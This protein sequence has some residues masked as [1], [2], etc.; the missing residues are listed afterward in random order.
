MSLQVGG[1]MASINIRI[2]EELKNRA[3]TTL[4]GLGITP[5]EAIRQTLE[6]IASSVM[7]PFQ[8][9]E[10]SRDEA[11]FIAIVRERLSNPMSPVEMDIDDL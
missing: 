11:D 2:D 9:E 7:H 6:Y 5:S 3:F 8:N 4:E 10:L 1:R